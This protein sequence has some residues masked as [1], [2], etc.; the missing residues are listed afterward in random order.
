M[1]ILLHSLVSAQKPETPALS[2]INFDFHS[3]AAKLSVSRG[4]AHRLILST[5]LPSA[6]EKVAVLLLGK[7]F[8]RTRKVK[9][10]GG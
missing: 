9:L 3:R 6:L 5:Q 7:D 1:L 8:K 10:G 2:E 4:C